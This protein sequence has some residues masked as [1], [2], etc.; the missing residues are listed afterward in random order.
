MKIEV[1][2]EFSQREDYFPHLNSEIGLISLCKLSESNWVVERLFLMLTKYYFFY[3][4]HG[5]IILFS[6]VHRKK[7]FK[8]LNK[9]M[10]T[11]LNSSRCPFF[12]WGR[13]LNAYEIKCKCFM[14][15]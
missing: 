10:E 8:K 4:F 11:I 12:L 1:S 13:K 2:Y 15:I 3:V 9:N 7:L 14:Q 6:D 5:I